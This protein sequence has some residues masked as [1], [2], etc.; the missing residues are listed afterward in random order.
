ML[1]ITQVVKTSFYCRFILHSLKMK[2]A[3]ILV[4]NSVSSI[5]S[6]LP[7]C[8]LMPMEGQLLTQ[9]RLNN[10]QKIENITS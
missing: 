5:R 1:K 9:E 2:M 3:N 8:M 10:R 4:I 6:C 7:I